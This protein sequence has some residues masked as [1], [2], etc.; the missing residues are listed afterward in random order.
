[1]SRLLGPGKDAWRAVS[2]TTPNEWFCVSYALSQ[3]DGFS[4]TVLISNPVD[5]LIAFLD[6]DNHGFSI[7]GIQLVSPP[8]LNGSDSWK[9]EPLLRVWKKPSDPLAHVYEVADGKRYCTAYGE[10]DISEFEFSKAFTS[11]G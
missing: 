1:M 3:E 11:V 2:I 5:E 9:M 10:W 8:F 4:E 6:R 7:V